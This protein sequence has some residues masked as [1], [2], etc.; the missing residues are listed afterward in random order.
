MPAFVM[1]GV[2]SGATL[3]SVMRNGMLLSLAVFLG[4]ALAL[5]PLLGNTGLWLA[6]NGFFLA[7]GL[8]LWLGMERRKAGL[9]TA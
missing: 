8:I 1:D 4:M 7:R 3:N 6:L 9:F 5:Q 2:V